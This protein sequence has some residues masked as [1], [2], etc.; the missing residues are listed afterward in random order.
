MNRLFSKILIFSIWI[1]CTELSAQQDNFCIRGKMSGLKK[2]VT[3]SILTAEHKDPNSFDDSEIATTTVKKNGEFFISGYVDHPQKV[4]LITNN[5]DMLGDKAAKNNYKQVHWTYTTMW[6]EPAEYVIKTPKYSLLTDAPLTKDCIIEGGQAQKDFNDLNSAKIKHG[7]TEFEPN[8]DTLAKIE[9][10]FI[11][12]H[13]TSPVAINLACEKLTNGYNLSVE[14][15]D[16]LGKTIKDCPSDKQRYNNFVHR[17]EAA[18]LTANG[19][20]IVDLD[21]ITPMGERCQLADIVKKYEGKY[22]LIDF[23]ASWCG[24]CRAGTPKLKEYYSKY[25]HEWLEIIS[26]SADENSDAWHNAMQK[27]QMPWTQYCLTSQGMKDLMEKYQIIGVPY[28][29]LLSPDGKVI[30]N[31]SGVDIIESYLEKLK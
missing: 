2:G 3:I 10:D 21:M 5:L 28:Y 7:I 13:P 20:P 6:L 4:T 12:N 8:I 9:L 15:I 31:P 24:I 1:C 27:D 29:L 11:T 17:L 22:L 16:I 19:N 14:Q 26:V 23:W 18:R 30:A 25:P